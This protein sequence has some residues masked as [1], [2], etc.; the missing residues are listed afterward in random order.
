MA[1]DAVANNMT[2]ENY[3]YAK[4]HATKE[5]AEAAYETG[6]WANQKADEHNID[7]WAVAKKVGAAI[8]AGCSKAWTAAK[9]V[10]YGKHYDKATGKT[11][12]DGS[13]T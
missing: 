5:N 10:D 12:M 6:K 11:M 3:E 8:G 4:Q 1:A 13:S 9:G 7:K 2:Y